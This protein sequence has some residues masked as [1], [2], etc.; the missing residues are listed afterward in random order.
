MCN[1]THNVKIY[2]QWEIFVANLRTFKCKIC[3]PQMCECKINDKYQVSVLLTWSDAPIFFLSI[4][5]MEL[6]KVSRDVVNLLLNNQP[7]IQS[8]HSSLPI[9]SCQFIA[10]FGCIA[11]QMLPLKKSKNNHRL[12]ICFGFLCKFPTLASF[13][14][15]YLK[16]ELFKGILLVLEHWS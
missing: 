16:V 2:T 11:N 15:G 5:W 7:L 10:K 3:R 4:I 9:F 6:S 1:F 14:C 8:M 13:W 12:K